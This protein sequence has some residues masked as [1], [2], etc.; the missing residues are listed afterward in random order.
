MNV[1]LLM[2]SNFVTSR[3]DLYEKLDNLPFWP[4]RDGPGKLFVRHSASKSQM[5]D[6][7]CRVFVVKVEGGM[8]LWL[9]LS[10]DL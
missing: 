8:L 7:L 4:F 6:L 5:A 10:K 2:L 1:W 9:S 3:L